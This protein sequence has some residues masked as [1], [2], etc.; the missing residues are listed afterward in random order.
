[1]QFNL[2]RLGRQELLSK[3]N[4]INRRYYKI[5]DDFIPLNAIEF[6]NWTTLNGLK[7]YAQLK[8][9]AERYIDNLLNIPLSYYERKHRYT[10]AMSQVDFLQGTRDSGRTTLDGK[11]YTYVNGQIE[12]NSKVVAIT[13]IQKKHL[14]Y[15]RLCVI[16]NKPVDPRIY[17]IK[18]DSA[19]KV[20]KHA[21]SP[22]LK[23]LINKYIIKKYAGIKEEYVD[24]LADT[25]FIKYKFPQFKSIN[26]KI[27]YLESVKQNV[28]S[29]NTVVISTN[30]LLDYTS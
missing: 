30:M 22:K 27:E 21:P 17:I 19:Y 23:A 5:T 3:N 11:Y 24:N 12:L 25:V 9:P 14:D 16:F 7:I 29:E 1:M 6:Y 13:G 26:A 4:D 18:I 8:F 2:A 20:A 10:N 15:Y 28:I